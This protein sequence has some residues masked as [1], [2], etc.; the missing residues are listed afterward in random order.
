VTTTPDVVIFC[1][2]SS[3]I[4]WLIR[5][6]HDDLE[7]WWNPSRSLVTP[8]HAELKINGQKVRIPISPDAR[9]REAKEEFDRRWAAIEEA[10]KA[11]ADGPPVVIETKM[12]YTKGGD[13]RPPWLP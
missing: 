3:C 4:G 13:L 8:T 5:D 9:L 6:F 12:G 7:R 2:A 1:I 11:V 10:S